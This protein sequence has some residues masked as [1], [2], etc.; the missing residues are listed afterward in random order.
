VIPIPLAAGE[1]GPARAVR[2]LVH[3]WRATVAVHGEA[4]R[5]LPCATKRREELE[6]EE[7]EE[8]TVAGEG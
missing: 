3:C 5:R 2:G 1:D 8:D 6:Q 7:K 4:S